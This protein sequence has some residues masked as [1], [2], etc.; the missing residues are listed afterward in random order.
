MNFHKMTK[1]NRDI[2]IKIFIANY[3]YLVATFL[4]CLCGLSNSVESILYLDFF[5]L[6]KH[7]FLVVQMYKNV[8][9]MRRLW[10]RSPPE[11]SIIY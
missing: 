2:V 3:L 9:L 4:Q 10:V 6:H 11:K 1:K 5:V 7:D 8:I